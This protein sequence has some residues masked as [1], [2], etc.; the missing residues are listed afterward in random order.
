L[1]SKL[2]R[3]NTPRWRLAITCII[4]VGWLLAWV[5]ARM[6][7]VQAP[8]ERADA[9]LVLSGSSR[10]AERNH[11]AAQLFRDG[12]ASRII[13]TNDT[14]QLGWDRKEQRNLFAYEWARRILIAD[15]VP[16]ERIEVVFEPVTGTY[17]E[18]GVVQK[19]LAQGGVNSLLMVTSAYHSRRT[20][21]T[22]RHVFSGTHT[23][24]GLEHPNAFPSPWFW[25]LRRSGWR[26]VAGEYLKMVYYWLRFRG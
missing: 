22:A 4:L 6:L 14:M 10:V 21:W 2:R 5:A 3:F 7:V 17:E 12:R 25:W 13:L 15:G 24:I 9:I 20:L 18:L 11:F 26:M 16:A 19:Y 1:F 23:V 8:L